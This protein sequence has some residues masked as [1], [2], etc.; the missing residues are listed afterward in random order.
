VSVLL[1]I[2]LILASSAKR[3]AKQRLLRG[4]GR[5]SKFAVQVLDPPENL[6][7]AQFFFFYP[8]LPQEFDKNFLIQGANPII[9]FAIDCY[10][11]P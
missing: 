7:G 4:L 10:S 9:V 5:V 3:Q 11:D 8:G 1:L 2:D 6:P